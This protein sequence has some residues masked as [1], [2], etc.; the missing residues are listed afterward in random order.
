MDSVGIFRARWILWFR[1]SELVFLLQ[2]IWWRLIN[3]TYFSIF[4]IN[5]SI[6][7]I[8]FSGIL[9]PFLTHSLLLLSNF[10]CGV[11]LSMS[12]TLI[13]RPYNTSSSSRSTIWQLILRQLKCANNLRE[14]LILRRHMFLLL[15]LVLVLLQLLQ[16]MLLII[17]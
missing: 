5:R 2:L 13:F 10:I 9:I 1:F 11:S 8:I 6:Y 14:L 16:L 12:F 17:T 4:H 3:E 7:S 15:L